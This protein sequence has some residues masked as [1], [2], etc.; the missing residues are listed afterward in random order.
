MDIAAEER[1]KELERILK[2]LDSSSLQTKMNRVSTWYKEKKHNVDHKCTLR[3]IR[4]VLR[5]CLKSIVEIHD[6]AKL[7]LCANDVNRY[8]VIYCEL[9]SNIQ[10]WKSSDR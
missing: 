1:K 3:T 7:G 9:H 8:H 4:L 6:G 5:T 2:H 10:N